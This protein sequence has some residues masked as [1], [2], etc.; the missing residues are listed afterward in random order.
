MKYWIR[1]LLAAGVMLLGSPPYLAEASA[2]IQVDVPAKNESTIAPGRNFYVKGTYNL[3]A[4]YTASQVV[5]NM[6]RYGSQE[7]VRR[8][9]GN[10]KNP[11]LWVEGNTSVSF[12]SWG[13][14]EDIRNS[15]MPEL[16]WDGADPDSFYQGY[17]KCY[18]DD[19]GF[20]ALIPGGEGEIDDGMTLLDE[21]GSPYSV[22]ASGDYWLEVS[23]SC[24]DGLGNQNII[25][26]NRPITIGITEN[27]LLARFSP[28]RHMSRIAEWAGM[29][30]YRIYNDPF[31]GNWWGSNFEIPQEMRASDMTEYSAGKSHFVIYNVSSGST[32]YKVELARLQQQGAVNNS[33]RLA[34]YYYQ[35]GEP[36]LKDGR[37]SEITA[38]E[39]GD[40]LQLTR[41][42]VGENVSGGMGVYDQDDAAVPQYDLD[43]SDGIQA[44]AGDLIALYGVA[45][46]IQISPA[47]IQEIGPGADKNS[48]LLNNKISTLHYEITG[49]DIS[50]EMDEAVVLNRISGGGDQISELEFKH[51]LEIT[52]EMAAKDL[53]VHIMGYD[54]HGQAVAGTE[55][56]FQ[57]HVAADTQNPE[58][59]PSPEPTP[60]V[61]PAPSP[62]PL[63]KPGR[64]QITSISSTPRTVTV[65]WKKVCG[66][67]KY[68]VYR[69]SSKKNQWV[70]TAE[71]KKT[72]YKNKELLPAKDY[73]FRI[74]SIKEASDG[75]RS[76][77]DDSSAVK[78]LTHP[79]VPRKIRFRQT[80]NAAASGNAVLT[81]NVSKRADGYYVYQLKNGRYR[82]AYK[83]TGTKVY[84]RT[85]SKNAKVYKRIG[86]AKIKNGKIRCTLPGVSPAGSCQAY[87]KVRSYVAESGYQ[88]QNS[89]YSKPR[90]LY[91]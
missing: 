7:V 28:D 83:I 56:N 72:S 64:A 52:E 81:M 60:E 66:A 44:E 85:G 71:T 73:W 25:K 23:V 70:K 47:D 39:T 84:Q 6:Y 76:Y 82:V 18:F 51:V 8:V 2:S 45:A 9:Q 86:T 42:E 69:Y 5:V 22:L 10:V 91:Q 4:G 65:K 24:Q 17:T 15:G 57:I 41:A 19:I 90:K 12:N 49:S 88:Q 34:N 11:P 43:F 79:E 59:T 78:I 48:F 38:F 77:G 80:G 20:A 29:R 75:R 50:Q 13:S 33:S 54:A 63:K 21:S 35:Y 27:K 16:I 36:V 40:K 32:A 87:F 58:V 62:A 61:S 89:L 1:V 68:A 67:D 53:E 14:A 3:P 74:R 55:E 46:P 31:A 30:G 37:E 26:W